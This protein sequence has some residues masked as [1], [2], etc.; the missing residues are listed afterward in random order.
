MTLIGLPHLTE[1]ASAHAQARKPIESWQ[2][3]IKKNAF[4]HLAHLKQTFG[5]A[6]Y[7]PPDT[8]FDI[9][10]NKYRIVALVN[11]E[12][13]VVMVKAAMT[14]EQYAAWSKRRKK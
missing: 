4:K 3:L 10:G 2:A 14:H 6:D 7:V 1:F 8:I 13:Q 9:G 5:S 12:A 11:Y